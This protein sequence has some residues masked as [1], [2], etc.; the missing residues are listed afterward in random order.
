MLTS[1]SF[2]FTQVRLVSL[3]TTLW[4]LVVAVLHVKLYSP[5]R[6][7]QT[8][9]MKQLATNHI[10]YTDN[11]KNRNIMT[12]MYRLIGLTISYFNFFLGIS[13]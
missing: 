5:Q 9:S 4:F 12:Y 6:S 3:I 7:Y 10:N 2:Y 11:F 13:T 1:A 8:F